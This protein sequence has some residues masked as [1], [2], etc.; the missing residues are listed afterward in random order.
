MGRFRFTN[1]T[2]GTCIFSATAPTYARS[3]VEGL[4]AQSLGAR[5]VDLTLEP[6]KTIAGFL[7]D[8]RGAPIPDAEVCAT[9]IDS[10]PSAERART[11]VDGR[12]EVVGLRDESYRVGIGSESFLPEQLEEV[13]AGSRGLQVTLTRRASVRVAVV[14]GRGQPIT[15]YVLTVKSVTPGERVYGKTQWAPRLVDHALDGVGSISGLTPGGY[16][17]QVEAAGFA[18]AFSAPFEVAPP[19]AVPCLRVTLDEGGVIEGM[20]EDELGRPLPGVAVSTRSP[21]VEVN[22]FTELFASLIPSNQTQ[23]TVLTGNDGGFRIALLNEGDYR[24]MIARADRAELYVKDLTVRTG[25][26]TRVEPIGVE[27]GTSLEGRVM[28]H[29]AGIGNMVICITREAD[30]A[31]TRIST[32]TYLGKVETDS[33]GRYRLS[34]RLPA[35]RYM[36]STYEI[37]NRPMLGGGGLRAR[38]EFE[39]R[40]SQ[41]RLRLDLTCE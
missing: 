15:S 13:A 26:I 17:L 40:G 28:R 5:G 20:L 38:K 6:G 24:L 1:A 35:G 23:A 4:V 18:R 2:E 30:E 8:D 25:Q 14:D 3:T 34:K 21:D 22:P 11:G 41:Q 37:D 33:D 32:A 29:G 19:T 10:E 27:A 31:E 7:L 12:F 39:I 16:V 9:A 36:A